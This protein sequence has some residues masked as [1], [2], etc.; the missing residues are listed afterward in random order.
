MDGLVYTY[1]VDSPCRRNQ[2]I[3]NLHTRV[4]RKLPPLDLDPMHPLHL[5]LV[6]GGMAVAGMA[7]DASVCPHAFEPVQGLTVYTQT[8]NSSRTSWTLRQS[9]NFG[10][11]WERRASVA[12]TCAPGN[13]FVYTTVPA[14]LSKPLQLAAVVSSGEVCV[15]L[16]VDTKVWEKFERPVEE[17]SVPVTRLA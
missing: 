8:F 10:P 17:F 13:G 12:T 9:Q 14:C 16:N 7:V 4:L 1:N 5:Q 15:M 11:S 2:S 6:F 3:F